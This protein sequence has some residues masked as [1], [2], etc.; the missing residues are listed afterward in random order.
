MSGTILAAD[1]PMADNELNLLV[2]VNRSCCEPAIVMPCSSGASSS[3]IVDSKGLIAPCSETKRRIAIDPP[4]L[5]DRLTPLLISAGLVKGITHMSIR[6]Q[7]GAA[8]RAS[9]LW[10]LDGGAA[11]EPKAVC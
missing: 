11:D 5:S 1:M 9:A 3:M 10:P 7:S 2:P 4:S 6:K 8:I